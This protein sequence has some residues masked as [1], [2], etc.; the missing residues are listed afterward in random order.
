MVAWQLLCISVFSGLNETVIAINESISWFC[1]VFSFFPLL[2]DGKPINSRVYSHAQCLNSAFLQVK[3]SVF[4][5]V[6]AAPY[7][8]RDIPNIWLKMSN[9]LESERAYV[10]LLVFQKSLKLFTMWQMEGKWQSRWPSSKVEVYSDKSS[11]WAFIC[12]TLGPI[13]LCD[14]LG[15]KAEMSI[16]WGQ[17]PWTNWQKADIKQNNTVAWSLCLT[18]TIHWTWPIHTTRGTKY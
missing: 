17:D 2:W 11:H 13:C 1:A 16:I 14:L 8:I 6:S 10:S 3:M 7:C 12:C 18:Y 4:Q 15:A 5:N 9:S